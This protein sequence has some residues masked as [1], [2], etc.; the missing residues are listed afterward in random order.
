M[1]GANWWHIM[2]KHGKNGPSSLILRCSNCAGARQSDTFSYKRCVRQMS[3]RRAL[4]NA[5]LMIKGARKE[6]TA[7]RRRR[8]V[9]N[10]TVTCFTVWRTPLTQ[11]SNLRTAN[12]GNT[13]VC[14]CAHRRAVTRTVRSAAADKC[15]NVLLGPIQNKGQAHL[16]TMLHGELQYMFSEG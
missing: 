4:L 5:L 11:G 6:G 16:Q 10:S 12:V 2:S 1:C 13:L 15:G 9:V 7:A 14:C 8:R 3:D